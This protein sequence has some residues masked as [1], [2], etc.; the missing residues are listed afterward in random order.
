MR[1]VDDVAGVLCG[2]SVSSRVCPPRVTIFHLQLEFQNGILYIRRAF[3]P[4]HL[5][6]TSLASGTF[7]IARFHPPPSPRVVTGAFTAHAPIVPARAVDGA[8]VAGV[9]QQFGRR[10]GE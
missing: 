6:A 9:T 4:A 7:F 8:L 3:V 2:Q 10:S 1:S 5:S